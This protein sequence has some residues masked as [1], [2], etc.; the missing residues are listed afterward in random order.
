[1]I[2]RSRE[3]AFAS[4]PAATGE[5]AGTGAGCPQFPDG[6]HRCGLDRDHT[7]DMDV[8]PVTDRIVHHCTCGYGWT[9]LTG[10]LTNQIVTLRPGVRP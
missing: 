3:N 6:A 5:P 2:A 1:M 4:C 9:C 10:S 8:Q 7:G